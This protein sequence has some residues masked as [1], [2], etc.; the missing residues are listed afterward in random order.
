MNMTN[1]TKVSVM[2]QL[3]DHLPGVRNYLFS[4]M[5]LPLFFF[6]LCF[7]NIVKAVCTDIEVTM[8]M[9][10]TTNALIMLEMYNHLAGVEVVSW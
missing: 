10:S 2:L 5:P 7:C 6:P 9:L 8:N 4:H 3:H 1:V